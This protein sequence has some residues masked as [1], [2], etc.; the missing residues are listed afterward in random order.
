VGGSPPGGP[1]DVIYGA[2]Q[3]FDA[4][5]SP[6]VIN[7]TARVNDLT[8]ITAPNGTTGGATGLNAKAFVNYI[9][10]QGQPL[11]IPPG[12]SIIPYVPP[13]Q[14]GI[15]AFRVIQVGA[16]PNQFE[17]TVNPAAVAW[18]GVVS[19]VVVFDKSGPCTGVGQPPL[20]G[21]DPIT[22]TLTVSAPMN[23][24]PENTFGTVG[25]PLTSKFA[26]GIVDQYLANGFQLVANQTVTSF[27]DVSTTN[28]SGPINFT[29]QIVPGQNW[30]G[31][32]TGA[33]TVPVPTDIIYEAVG[34]NLGAATR[35]PV[36]INTQVIAGLPLGTYTAY[37][38]FTASPE[39]PVTVAGSV[40]C[41]AAIAT[42]ASGTTQPACIPIV[43]T[44]TPGTPV[45]IPNPIVFGGSLTPQQ[46]G[47]PISN[48]LGNN[49]NFNFTAGY[50]PTPV[51]GT[52]LPA[53]NVFFVGTGTTL[54][55]ATVGNSVSGV[56]APGG[57][58]TVPIQVNPVGLPTGV[59]SGQL[60]VSG[61]GQASGATPQTTVPL[62]V[63]VGPHAGEDLPTGN[64]LGLMLPVNVPPVG[65]GVLPG[66]GNHPSASP[67]AYQLILSVPSG[68]G[69]NGPNQ[70]ANPTLLQVTGLNNTSTTPYLVNAPTVSSLPGVSITNVGAAFGSAASN[71]TGAG[72]FAQLSGLPGSPL[73]PT[74]AWSLWVDASNLNASNT[75][76]LAACAVSGLPGDDFGIT[77]TVTFNPNGGG[78]QF[79]PLVVPVTVCITDFPRLVLGMP[80][81]FPNP[82]FGT[83]LPTNVVPGFT[84]SIVEMVLGSSGQTAAPITLFSTAGNST[85]V[86]KV[87][88]IHTN[89]GVI[90]TV[91][92]APLS[93]QVLSLAQAPAAFLGTVPA[94]TNPFFVVGLTPIPGTPPFA[95]GPVAVGPGMQTFQIC[96]NTDPLGNAAGTFPFTVTINGA[97]VGAITVPINFIVANPG[98][99]GPGPG[100]GP[101]GV[102]TSQLGVF[103]NTTSGPN[104]GLGQWWLAGPSNTFDASTKGPRWFGLNGDIGVAGD[105]TGSGVVRIG[106]FRCPAAGV[107]QWYI[108][109]NNNGQ[110]DGTF[111]G[112]VIWNFGLTGDQPVVGDWNGT[113]V[114]KIGV[115]RCPAAGV[116]TWY[117][118]I[119]NQHTYDPATVGTY[120][121]G[122][123][124]DKAVV[125][126]Y[127]GN[128]ATDNIGVFRCPAVGVCTWFV[129]NIGQ[130]GLSTVIPL[131]VATG[132]TYSF[133]LPGDQP[134][135]GNW[136]NSGT[137]RIGIFRN[138]GGLGT[139]YVDTNGNH[140]FDPG[141]DQ[142]FNFGLAGDQGVTGFWTM[143]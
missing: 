16:A 12:C 103:R 59:Y 62:I 141:A 91:T 101:G 86:C 107:C 42:V 100:P 50:S 66:A 83:G 125:G 20:D 119:G 128:G 116:C 79:A 90:P 127:A 26:S 58:F 102:N 140:V 37:I 143:P 129:D 77:G 17:V 118:D 15:P 47:L 88:D 51:F 126:P 57:I 60:L 82:T 38:L 69:P 137:K 46:T 54:I 33:A 43:I 56:I 81:F 93:S 139:W 14:G 5:A 44:V 65:T 24:I 45:N 52:A 142:I 110:W 94:F 18:P 76:H 132:T 2:M 89:G 71:C 72:T 117:L 97:G 64:G 11:N 84:Q 30:A 99:P 120:L 61:N 23:L 111:G 22:L 78:I 31:P 104:T 106:V 123:T 25:A 68:Y 35:I 134:V 41:S 10:W 112:D 27:V 96:A 7:F 4:I 115:M 114:S 53:A 108:D 8:S 92:I 122:L 98:A 40:A 3:F 136:N 105:W 130:T 87:L 75:Q 138:V 29:V 49:A 28:S 121:F 95:A 32:V 13:A 124:G 1:E 34:Q 63:Y 85:L 19:S 39:T 74:C 80:T 6:S 67:G 131:A 135:V 36:S 73:G 9:N 55:P 70:I 133:G 113:G 21:W 109:M 48:Q